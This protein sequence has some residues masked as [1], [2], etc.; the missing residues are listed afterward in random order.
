[1]GPVDRA[2][3]GEAIAKVIDRELM[4]D[5]KNCLH[6]GTRPVNATGYLCGGCNGTY[7]GYVTNADIA[8]QSGNRKLAHEWEGKMKEFDAR[9]R[10]NEKSRKNESFGGSCHHN[11]NVCP[12]CEGITTC[13]CPAPKTNVT[14]NLCFEC[15]KG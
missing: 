8:Y 13:R 14:H 4:E 11:K 9:V 5:N 6:C 2:L 10:S 12:Q 3:R 15:K 7:R 1:M